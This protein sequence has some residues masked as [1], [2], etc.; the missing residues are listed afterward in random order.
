VL[1]KYRFS[2]NLSDIT[3]DF[4][5]LYQVCNCSVNNMSCVLRKSVYSDLSKCYTH[6]SSGSLVIT[7]T[8]IAK[9][10]FSKG[11]HVVILN[12]IKNIVT[13]V[14]CFITVAIFEFFTA[15]KIQVQ[16]SWVMTPCNVTVRYQHFGSGR[17]YTTATLHDVIT[18]NAASWICYCTLF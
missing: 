10:T 4:L 2:P 14:A 6:S 8:F 13:K 3:S 7:I 1:L 12:Y 11:R 5:H 17:W 16:I 9:W 15:V 18:Q